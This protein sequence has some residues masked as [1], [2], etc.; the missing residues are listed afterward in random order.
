MRR[1]VAITGVGLVTPIGL[2][3]DSTWDALIRGES[4]AGPITQFDTTDHS[5]R[6][7]CEV[8]DFDPARHMDRKDARRADRFL[9]FAMAAAD[10]AVTAAGFAQ[11][12]GELPPERGGVR[13]GV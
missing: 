12:V 6:F 10:Q 11:G 2:D 1:R 8:K 13:I 7:A 5:V 9:H 3:P 4:G